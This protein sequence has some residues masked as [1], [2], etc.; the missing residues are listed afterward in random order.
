VSIA[1]KTGTAQLLI[2]GAYKKVHR[3]TFV[4]YFPEE[5][6]EY[7]C[8]CMINHPQGGYDAGMDCGRVVR[9]I[10]EKTMAYTGEYIYD[11]GQWVWQRRNNNR[12]HKTKI[13]Q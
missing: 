7:T 1:G 3:I 4:G 10:A 13:L 5:E 9:E 12:Q 6:P 8:L 11:N 2:N